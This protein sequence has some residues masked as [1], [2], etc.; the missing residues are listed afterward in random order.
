M[1]WYI[2]YRHVGYGIMAFH[3]RADAI[4]L[5]VDDAAFDGKLAVTSAP[6]SEP[7]RRRFAH[8]GERHLPNPAF[9]KVFT[10]SRIEL[11]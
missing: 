1:W 10:Q 9:I 6:A 7:E 2:L 8:G 4:V 11:L 5:S 3:R